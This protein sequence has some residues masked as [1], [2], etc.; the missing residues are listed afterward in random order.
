MKEKLFKKLVGRLVNKGVLSRG[1]WPDLKGYR[2]D[3]DGYGE[4]CS[5]WARLYRARV[6]SCSVLDWNTWSV[7]LR[8]WKLNVE[9]ELHEGEEACHKDGPGF[10]LAVNSPWWLGLKYRIAAR[11]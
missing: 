6:Y 4:G 7:E 11:P 8:L 10:H 2:E 9:L 3:Y 5:N 1:E